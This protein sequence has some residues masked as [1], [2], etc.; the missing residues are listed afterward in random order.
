MQYRKKLFW[1]ILYSLILASC[2]PEEEVVK[3][4]PEMS[5]IVD[6]EGN[7][8]ATVKIGSQ[9]WMAEDLRS[10]K[11]NNGKAVTFINELD[12]A[13]W[14]NTLMP[15]YSNGLHGKLYNF[16]TIR[17]TD[18]IAPE[19]WHVATEV[20]WQT[21]ETHLGMD[22]DD[23]NQVNWRGSDQGDKLKQDYQT[24]SWRNFANVW[25]TNDSGFAALP[26]GCRLFDGRNCLPNS[27]EQG[28]WW[29][30]TATENEAWFRNLDY[31]K[32]KI[33]R[34]FADMNYG[35][36]IRCVKD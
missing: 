27:A 16:H 2:G 13:S 32:S 21:L 20:D 15:A 36:A 1:F 18:N 35:Y 11:Y 31:K 5:S 25:G 17:N 29:T 6:I 34:Y 7:T 9:W 3:P 30:A 23:I 22:N 14:A 26:C 12:T 10:T 24:R 33:F 28:F 4:K 19:G 8:Y